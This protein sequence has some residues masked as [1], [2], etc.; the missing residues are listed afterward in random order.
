[1]NG[2]ERVH[3]E[4][5]LGSLTMFDRLI[6]KGH[7]SRLY[8][9]GALR[10]FLWN[11]GTPL[12]GFAAYAKGCTH[13]LLDHAE[14][15]AAE[16]GRPSIYLAGSVTRRSGQTKDEMARAIAE[17]DGITDGLMAAMSASASRRIS[18]RQAVQSRPSVGVR[19]ADAAAERHLVARRLADTQRR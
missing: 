6:F 3:R 12:T 10:V 14:R 5:V 17:R 13:A 8:V 2:F 7:L 9:P 19:P 4:R 15:I 1:M 18:I 16:T 11:Q